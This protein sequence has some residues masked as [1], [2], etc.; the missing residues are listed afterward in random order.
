MRLP[1]AVTAGVSAAAALVL[2]TACGGGD[3]GES[4]ASGSS[5]GPGSAS[6][7]P[8]SSSPAGS[9]TTPSGEDV[10]AFCADAGTVLTDLNTAFDNATD[11][12]QLPALLDQAATSLQSVQPPAEIADS[13]AGFAGAIAQLAGASR[14]VDLST[15]EG[16]AQFT[17][18]YEALT[19]QAADAQQ[20]VDAYVT[21]HCPGL[22]SSP[23]G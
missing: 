22:A 9:S 18:Q 10:Q 16:Q 23:S 7:S 5:A 1:P 11:P 2:L 12:T 14:Q 20:D 15:A 8:A 21:A 3:S 13:W 4:Q 17:Q 19:G 6:S